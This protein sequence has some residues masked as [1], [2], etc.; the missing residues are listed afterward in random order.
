MA[1]AYK[2][3]DIIF[4][5]IALLEGLFFTFV[6]PDNY[7]WKLFFS[8]FG[9]KVIRAL[10]LAIPFLAVFWPL[11]EGVYR[12]RLFDIDISNPL[13]LIGLFLLV[14]FLYYVRHLILHRGIFWVTH[15]AHH[16]PRV[17]NFASGG[18]VSWESST[19]FIGAYFILL[20]GIWLGFRPDIIFIAFS[21]D[22]IL[23]TWL[24]TTRIKKI[25]WLE[26]ILNTPSHHR[27]HHAKNPEYKTANYGG[28][29]IIFDRI[30]GTFVPEDETLPIEYGIR[31]W[32]GSYNPFKI[33]LHEWKVF[34]QKLWK[35]RTPKDLG[36]CLFGGR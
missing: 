4:P 31:G 1:T 23:Q 20:P 7:D 3:A 33:L 10:L 13:Y 17:L 11:A 36:A 32:E 18:I 35:V 26:I 16:S 22:V 12:H 21:L 19:L 5:L 6:I 29:L 25:G 2:Y 8:T 24:H 14:D 34:F 9:L 27:V 30:F 15:A 28:L